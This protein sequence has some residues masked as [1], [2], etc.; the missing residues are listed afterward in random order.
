MSLST[1]YVLTNPAMPDLVK[2]GMTDGDDPQTRLSQLYTTGL[3]FPFEL[4]FAC[5]V[6]NPAEVEKALHTAFAPQRVNPKREFF[7]I[8][9]A[10]AIAILKLLHVED[11]THAIAAEAPIAEQADVAAGQEYQR[12]RRPNL[13]FEQMQIPIGSQLASA[14]T[15]DIAIVI[16]P[17]KVRLREQEIS[18]TAATRLILGID[19]SVSPGH[20][21]KFNGRSISDIY[22]ETYPAGE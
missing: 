5:R 11:T 1:V 3:P 7:K 17:K 12:T 22:E 8:D 13:N 14:V 15:D 9:P 10:Q 18:L 16:G 19:Y 6:S 4:K 2:I 21:W 20:F